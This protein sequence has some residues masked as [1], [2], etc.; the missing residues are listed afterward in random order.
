M[1]LS[2]LA[3]ISQCKD[4]CSLTHEQVDDVPIEMDPQN[5]MLV[6]SCLLLIFIT[7]LKVNVIIHSWVLYTMF[8]SFCTSSIDV[9]SSYIFTSHVDRNIQ[10]GTMLLV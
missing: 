6:V 5:G 3:L 8:Y 10:I 2:Q 1:N 9:P 4:E 7:Y